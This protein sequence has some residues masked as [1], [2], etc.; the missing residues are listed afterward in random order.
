MARAFGCFLVAVT[1]GMTAPG[2]IGASFNSLYVFGDSL[3]DSGNTYNTVLSTVGVQFPPP[4]Y[5]QRGTNGRVAAEY[6]ANSFGFDLKPYTGPTGGTNFAYFGAATGAY[7]VSSTV[8]PGTTITTENINDARF[9]LT[10]LRNTGL[11]SQVSA[12]L[13]SGQT[14]NASSTLFMVWGGP[15]DFFMKPEAATIP[16]AI[17]NLSTSITRLVEDGG[18]RKLLIPNLP[19]LGTTPAARFADLAQP[20]SSAAS[21]ALSVAFNQGY[22]LTLDGLESVLKAK[23]SDLEIYRFD[24]F[25][26]LTGLLSNASALG[27]TNSTSPCGDAELGIPFCANP[28]EYVFW[29]SVH[30]TDRVHQI[31]AGQ[32][33]AAVPEPRTYALLTMGALMLFAA[34]RARSKRV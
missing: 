20:G 34:V 2:A 3:S 13:G 10:P 21:T 9:G 32:F 19:N 28:N 26:A 17:T 6:L 27:F 24:T 18:A 12:F 11:G 23:Y 31:L 25:A 7:T 29:D 4:P 16:T 33:A 15:N 8:A 30:P 5:N 22:S 14:F 1:F